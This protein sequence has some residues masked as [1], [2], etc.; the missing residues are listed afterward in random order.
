MIRRRDEIHATEFARALRICAVAAMA[1][2]GLAAAMPRAALA[3][4]CGGEAIGESE[5]ARVIDG[6]TVRLRDGGE[7]RLAGLAPVSR[8][9]AALAALLDG[10]RVTLLARD[11]TPDRYGRQHAF[12]VPAGDAAPVQVTLLAQGEALASGLATPP[13]CAAELAAAEATARAAGRGLWAVPGTV[14]DAARPAEIL[15]KLGQFAIVEG[16]VR[17]VRQAGA[18]VYVNFGPRWTRDFAATISRRLLP[19][20]EGAGLAPLSLAHRRVRVRGVI[21]RRGGP[22]IEVVEVGQIDAASG[23]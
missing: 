23:R 8:G 1:L 21:E 7:I 11:D 6:R 13:A 4:A 2:S 3:S 22:R 14:L 15:A 9:G 12:P 16:E 18:T 5:V 10:R 17:S 20:F 19:A